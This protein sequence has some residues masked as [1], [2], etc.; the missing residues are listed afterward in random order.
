MLDGQKGDREHT[1]AITHSLTTTE[2][3]RGK[4]MR[5]T[6]LLLV[7]IVFFIGKTRHVVG[8]ASVPPAQ[9]PVPPVQQTTVVVSTTATFNN[10]QAIGNLGIATATTT[11][12]SSIITNHQTLMLA[13]L[14]SLPQTQ[15][16]Q[17]SDAIILKTLQ[18][19]KWR[20]YV[21]FLPN[22][23]QQSAPTTMT[24]IFQGFADQPNKGIVQL[25][26]NT[27]TTT[28]SSSTATSNGNQQPTTSTTTTMGRWLSKPS[29]IRKGK[30]QLSARWK[31]KLFSTDEGPSN[32]YI[33]KGD[34]QASPPILSTGG[35]R[36][37]DAQMAGTILMPDT[38]VM[39]GKFR[40]DLISTDVSDDEL[41]M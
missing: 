37:V 25:T 16:Q 18:G 20:L 36:G 29:E 26:T 21:D 38:E 23:Q 2:S 31:I 8:L 32:Y 27:A 10:K 12:P 22:V 19:T 11:I 5:L 7:L 35:S 3:R 15:A 1:M 33:F 34:I 4:A 13:T 30:V 24:L 39:V 28:S 14:P 9:A 17:I 40:A 41:R 6:Y